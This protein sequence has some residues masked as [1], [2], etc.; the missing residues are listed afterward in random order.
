MGQT[1]TGALLSLWKGESL[2]RADGRGGTLRP[3][4]GRGMGERFPPGE[5][6][7]TSANS[8]LESTARPSEPSPG[9]LRPPGHRGGCRDHRPRPGTQPRR[10]TRRPG[11]LAQG[12]AGSHPELPQGAELP[13]SIPGALAPGTGEGYRSGTRTAKEVGKITRN[14]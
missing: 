14:W 5:T 8:C 6:P 7:G 13:T 4:L 12:S 10:G 11:Q 9:G 1:P 3:G 2:Q